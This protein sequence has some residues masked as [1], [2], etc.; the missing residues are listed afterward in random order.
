M[1][2][3]SIPTAPIKPTRFQPKSILIYGAPKCGKT[4][5][6]S[7]LSLQPNS[8]VLSTDFDGYSSVEAV[9]E[10]VSNVVKFEKYLQFLES[11]KVLF[12]YLIVDN[13]TRLDEF[14]EIK[15]TYDYMATNAGKS[16]N[17]IKDDN[18]I[19]TGHKYTHLDKGWTTILDDQGQYG[20]RYTRNAMTNWFNRLYNISKHLVLVAHIKE[21]KIA[22]KQGELIDTATI[23]LTG[24]LKTTFASL[25][26]GIAQIKMDGS[27]RYL[28]FETKDLTDTTSIISGCRYSYLAGEKILISD[29]VD[30]EVVTY[31]ENIFPSIK[32]K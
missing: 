9:Y 16:L 8:L 11:Q 6:C 24:K 13:I 1:A 12:D 26:D 27:K 28:G 29:F 22:T 3:F 18:G 7:K 5:I 30:N 17:L 4:A 32:E 15:G 19:P 23:D 31:W 10:D 21:T 14:S 2:E 20:Y 25:V